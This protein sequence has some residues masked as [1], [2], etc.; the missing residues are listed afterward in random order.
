MKQIVN[1]MNYT[2]ITLW[3]MPVISGTMPEKWQAWVIKEYALKWAKDRFVC[4]W[5]VC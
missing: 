2:K 3:K 1:K 5:F 4:N